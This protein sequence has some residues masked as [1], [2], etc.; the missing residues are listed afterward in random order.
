MKQFYKNR[1]IN[2]YTYYPK[3]CN[4]VKLLNHQTKEIHWWPYWIYICM[5]NVYAT[6]NIN[7]HTYSIVQN[8][9]AK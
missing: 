6:Q 9:G 5:Y 4:R 3:L 1:F 7:I 2:T 8:S